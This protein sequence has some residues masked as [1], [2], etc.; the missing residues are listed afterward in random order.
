MIRLG[1]LIIHD[2]DQH[3]AYEAIDTCLRNGIAVFR[4]NTGN[5]FKYF[6]GNLDSIKL[7]CKECD[8]T[9]ARVHNST[10]YG[11]INYENIKLP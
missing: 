9:L 3:W 5:G 4:A 7:L 11:R 2:V 8:W 10:E 1:N 6:T